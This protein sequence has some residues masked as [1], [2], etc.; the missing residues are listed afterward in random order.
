VAAAPNG[1]AYALARYQPFVEFDPG[2]GSIAQLGSGFT[3]TEWIDAAAV[4]L[5]DGRILVIGGWNSDGG[6][7]AGN[8]AFD[9]T[10]LDT[11]AAQ[12]PSM[13]T[14]RGGCSAA[15]ANGKVYVVGGQDDAGTALAT[16]EILDVATGTWSTGPS[17]ATPRS[18]PAVAALNGKVFVIGG[19]G[20]A[21][22]FGSVEVLD[23]AS[24]TA[25]SAGPALLQPRSR[26]AA[27]ALDWNGAIYLLGG[28][29]PVTGTRLDIE[30]LYP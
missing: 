7:N 1:K 8:R 23:A 24:P 27:A 14:A 21:A 20:S 25:W 29:S 19:E 22:A 18:Y 5:P 10:T 13:P 16:V 9:T 12:F 17:L 26:A 30:G 2:T 15:Y 3:G 6:V 28:R 11:A 4:G